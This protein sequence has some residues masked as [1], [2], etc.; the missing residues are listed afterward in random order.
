MEKGDFVQTLGECITAKAQE[1]D[2]KRVPQMLESYR[3][4]HTCEKN[5]FDLLVKRSLIKEDPYKL[6]KKVT[7]IETPDT[8]AFN[9]TE[10]AT[11]MGIRL[12]DYDTMLDYV[13]SYL[14]LDTESL[15][16]NKV[17][18]LM[19][20]NGF[21]DWAN[22]G[23]NSNQVNTR[24]V[25]ELIG[26]VRNGAQQMTQRLIIDSLNNAKKALLDVNVVLKDLES[27]VREKTKYNVRHL[28]M[29]NTAFNKD[30]AA[31]SAE[32]ERSEI[33]RLWQA[34]MGKMPYNNE[35]VME[36][37]KEDFDPNAQQL[38]Q[39]V[40]SSLKLK[41]AVKKAEKAKADPKLL[42]VDAAMILASCAPQL[43]QVLQKVENNHDVL[44]TE[45]A[46]LFEKFKS[47]L[48]RALG[49]SD[50]PEE[51]EVVITNRKTLAK[52]ARLINYN[53]FYTSLSK[54]MKL[55]TLIT[56]R[57]SPQYARISASP[58]SSLFTFMT[59]Q[60]GEMQDVII[61]LEA[62]DEYFKA[63]KI[64]GDKSRIKGLKIELA[65][66]GNCIVKTRGRCADFSSEMEESKAMQELGIGN[67]E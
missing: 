45:K 26:T 12:S 1:F 24:I 27:F 36:I 34:G 40:L 57:A 35:L 18:K 61:V 6:E 52:T 49:L 5:I 64:K 23:V 67:K 37:V 54:R 2:S 9:E 8:G 19:S 51:Y 29:Q 42:L 60:L 22:M 53:E 16:E 21:I 63:Q 56:N 4:L 32:A 59:K 20:L 43:E 39:A 44:Q 62:L 28:V 15:T 31:Q 38:R 25:S 65:T 46:T 48:R 55:Y 3:L 13:C 58:P 66:L 7:K 33:K 50:P 10:T 41:V 47:A 14:S 30:K 17:K 11:V